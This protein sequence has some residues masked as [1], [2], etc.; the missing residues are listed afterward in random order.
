VI[1]PQILR[2][3]T[4][5][6]VI[7]FDIPRLKALKPRAVRAVV[8]F[9][10]VVLTSCQPEKSS[11]ITPRLQPANPVLLSDQPGSPPNNPTTQ[12]ADTTSFNGAETGNLAPTFD[13]K[14]VKF[15]DVLK[16]Y[17]ALNARLDKVALPLRR[18]NATLC[19]VTLRD[20]GFSLHTLSDYPENLQAVA[21]TLLGVTDRLSIRRVHTHPPK[22]SPPV[23]PLLSGDILLSLDGTYLPSGKSAKVMFKALSEDLFAQDEISIHVQRGTERLKRSAFIQTLCGYPVYVF[24]GDYVNGHTDGS[25]IWIT[26]ELIRQTPHDDSLALIIAH[27][28]AHA[29]AGHVKQ[30]PNK[31]LE[32]EADYMA[33]I[34]IAR[35]G[36]NIDKAIEAWK[37]APHRGVHLQ[38]R[39]TTHPRLDDRSRNFE[40]ARRYIQ[41]QTR[42]G[43]PLTF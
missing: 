7:R 25:E 24:F 36:F 38:T 37:Y 14:E 32:L 15:S 26:S 40:R 29:I 22:T 19:P 11:Q 18:A 13:D 23:K 35:A 8:I 2:P 20:P 6:N 28:M 43:R 34:L 9:T 42:L 12:I 33:L 3:D 4:K 39:S 21:Q 41:Q 27:E 17:Q 30:I 10:T 1:R 5:F 31:K 16:A